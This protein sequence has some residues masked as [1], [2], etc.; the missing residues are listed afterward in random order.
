MSET[1]GRDAARRLVPTFLEQS[2]QAGTTW[3][4]AAADRVEEAGLA[5]WP[6]VVAGSVVGVI[7]HKPELTAAAGIIYGRLSLPFADEHGDSIYPQIIAK[8]TNFQLDE[9]VRHGVMCVE[10]D[11]R[12]DKQ[13]HIP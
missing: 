9:V 7:K 12:P 5:S 2:V 11:A 8:A 6:D 10:T 3:A 1:E 4:R 13:N